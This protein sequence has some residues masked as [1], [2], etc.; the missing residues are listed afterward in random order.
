LD[1]QGELE[2]LDGCR[3][4]GAEY[5]YTHGY[6]LPEGGFVGFAV[7]GSRVGRLRVD[8]NPSKD[9][10][11]VMDVVERAQGRRPTRVDVAVD[12][13]GLDVGDFM[14]MRDR[15]KV[16][17]F[18]GRGGA[19]ES[20]QLGMRSSKIVHRV[21][22]KAK[23]QGLGGLLMRCEAQR[24]LGP[25]DGAVFCL[26]RE[27]FDKLAV[28][29]RGPVD[30]LSITERAMLGHLMRNPDEMGELGKN[31][32]Q[33]YKALMASEAKQLDP[34]PGD[35]FRSRYQ[36]LQDQLWSMMDETQQ[37]GRQGSCAIPVGYASL[38]SDADGMPSRLHK[39]YYRAFHAGQEDPS[40]TSDESTCP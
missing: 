32:R 7:E 12:Y 27:V 18:R 1:I 17:T 23:E 40:G 3:R 39:I 2:A 37:W 35:V 31:A 36:A 4:V 34:T 26:D 24:R 20:F 30:G 16:M 29:Q 5:P 28:Y 10:G 15:V 25:T 38:I 11:V 14:P 13:P 9:A 6:V 8:M 33:K 22:D 21:Y 19:V